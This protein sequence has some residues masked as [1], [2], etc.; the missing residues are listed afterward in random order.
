MV[1][2]TDDQVLKAIDDN[3]T[4]GLEI[5]RFFL[6]WPLVYGVGSKA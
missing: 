6:V 5:N 1:K 3:F 2:A 4:V